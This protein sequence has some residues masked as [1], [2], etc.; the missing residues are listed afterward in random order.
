M[1]VQRIKFSDLSFRKKEWIDN[2]DSKQAVVRLGNWRI[3]IINDG[4]GAKF[5]LYEVGISNG[6]EEFLSTPYAD[7]KWKGCG[8]IFGW[9]DEKDVEQICNYFINRFNRKLLN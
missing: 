7:R 1:K 9:K 5:G 3:S 8:G 4:Y 6:R 2:A